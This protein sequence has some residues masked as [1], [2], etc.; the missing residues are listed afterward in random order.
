MRLQSCNR[1]QQKG[2]LPPVAPRR[3]PFAPLPP[4]TASPT[5]QKK[6]KSVEKKATNAGENP[7]SPD[8]KLRREGESRLRLRR[9]NSAPFPTVNRSVR[10]LQLPESI[11]ESPNELNLDRR[12]QSYIPNLNIG[13]MAIEP[14]S[15]VHEEPSH[16]LSNIMCNKQPILEDENAPP[17]RV[18]N[19]DITDVTRGSYQQ[20]TNQLLPPIP[21]DEE[22]SA[23]DYPSDKENQEPGMEGQCKRGRISDTL[24]VN[25]K[26]FQPLI[27]SSRDF[28]KSASPSIS[29]DS[30]QLGQGFLTKPLS[31]RSS[32]VQ[33]L[34]YMIQRLKGMSRLQAHHE[35]HII[36]DST[37]LLDPKSFKSLK[38]LEGMKEVRV[39]IPQI[40]IR[41]L[42]SM[43][44]KDKGCTSPTAVL[45]WIEACMLK[46]PSWIHVQNS[47]ESLPPGG[48][49]PPASPH[50][51][52]S[53]CTSA[54]GELLSP[55]RGDYVLNCAIL[56]NN[57]VFDGQVA[58]LTNDTVLKIRAM[59]EG[60]TCEAATSFC[61][62]LLNPYS[63]RFLWIGSVAHRTTVYPASK[64][65]YHGVMEPLARSGEEHVMGGSV[66]PAAKG[67]N[68]IIN[69][70]RAVEDLKNH[71]S[72]A[73]GLKVVLSKCCA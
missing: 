51:A 36:I 64:R 23:D 42:D 1:Q 33:N 14:L 59:A 25:R 69:K 31:K 20:A 50:H 26:P 38:R 54:C 60:L 27:L 16:I 44:F 52:P 72:Q 35:W 53:V 3:M 37:C 71:C 9:C 66:V 34:D 4:N 73:L 15:G 40:V 7:I 46:Y 43:N 10:F 68:S 70:H 56:F 63:E 13:S 67:M 24:D 19:M 6:P 17:S 55:T 65:S 45:K 62:S 30:G 41:E 28:S 48:L 22:L 39:I 61:E 12:K 32:V 29:S 49:T 21:L 58:L 18:K 8:E 47:S 5:I 2:R 11:I 57:T